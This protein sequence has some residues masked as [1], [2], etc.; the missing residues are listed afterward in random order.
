[1]PAVWAYSI[2]AP[3]NTCEDARLLG[4]GTNIQYPEGNDQGQAGWDIGLDFK[5]IFNLAQNLGNL[6]A[7]L[8]TRLAINLH[9]CPGKIDAAGG[10]G[11]EATMFNSAQLFNTY[12]GPLMF[13]NSMLAAEA[14]VLIMGCNVAKGKAG[15]EFLSDLSRWAFRGHKVVGFSRIGETL[16]Q[17]RQGEYCSEPGMRDTTYDEPSAG[18]PVVQVEREQEVLSLPWASETSPHAKIAKDGKII[19]GEEPLPPGTDYSAN[20]YMIGRWTVSAGSWN[21]WFIFQK[22]KTVYW[23]NEDGRGGKHTGS[24]GSFDGAV[25][26]SFSDDPPGWKRDWQV[27]EPLRSTL[28]GR[29]YIKGQPHGFFIMSKQS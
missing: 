17:Y 29:V 14:V 19:L 9:G 3:G 20:S 4:G 11:T 8:I 16:R 27:L 23:M 7:G 24:W 26:W 1:M 10:G 13:I 18:E 21:G 2:T 28:N 12:S 25:G 5:E 15:E 6:K 22:D